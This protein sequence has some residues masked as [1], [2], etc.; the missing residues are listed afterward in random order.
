MAAIG[1]GRCASPC[2]G[3]ASATMGTETCPSVFDET[4]Q[5]K[6]QQEEARAQN[7]IDP[8]QVRRDHC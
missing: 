7:Q 3:V 5:D 2:K 8:P 1:T 4:W 6:K